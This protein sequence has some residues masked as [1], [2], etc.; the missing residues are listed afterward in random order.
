[1][2][3]VLPDNKIKKRQLVIYILIM[4]ICIISVI[5]AFYVQ[6][7]A[8]IDLR[9][10]I[11]IPVQGELGKKSEEEVEVLKSEFNEIFTN[12]IENEEQNEN[13]KE[14]KD[15]ALV[16]T[17]YEKKESKLNSYDLE[18]H[19]P[20]INI[21]SEIIDEYNKEIEDIFVKIAN[22]VLESTNNNIIY[23][24][25]YKANVQD[26]NIITNNKI[27]FKR[28]FKSTKSNNTNIQL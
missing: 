4:V 6:F 19:I 20:H 22:N 27:K 7:Y 8:R 1:M 24:V 16:Y 25:E 10:L 11:G 13:K 14:E 26:R 23:T 2:N 17:Q 5:I 28:R 9:R 3:V 21:K 12:S 18:I 15:K